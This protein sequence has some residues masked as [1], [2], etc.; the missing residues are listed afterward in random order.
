MRLTSMTVALCVGAFFSGCESGQPA[1][2]Y[3]DAATNSPGIATSTT[4]TMLVNVD[5]AGLALQGYDPVAYFTDKKPVKGSARFSSTYR[6]ATYQFASAD[7]KAMFDAEPNKYEPQF[8]GF[9]AYAASIDKISPISVEYW[10]VVDGRLLLQHNQKAWD[11]WHKDASGNL[12][13]ADSNWPHLSRPQN[14]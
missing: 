2:Q 9:C 10:E 12:L 1:Y 5:Q 3:R 7:H 11:L 6:G 4:G 14:P 8:G 13:K